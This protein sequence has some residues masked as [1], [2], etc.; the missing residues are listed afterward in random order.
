MTLV[1]DAE[2]ASDLVLMRRAWSLDM[3]VDENEALFTYEKAYLLVIVLSR[4]WI[5]LT[6]ASLEIEPCQR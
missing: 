5:P 6:V 1:T 3:K 2:V 4:I